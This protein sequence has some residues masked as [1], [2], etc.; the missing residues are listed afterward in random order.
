MVQ[1][2]NHPVCGSIKVLSPPVKYSNAEPS[3]RLPP[4]LL[5]EHTEEILLEVAGLDRKR[6]QELKSKGVVA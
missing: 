3:I 1:E 6:V 2:I 5:G 4:P